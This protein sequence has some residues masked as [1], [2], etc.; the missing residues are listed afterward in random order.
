MALSVTQPFVIKGKPDEST[1]LNFIFNGLQIRKQKNKF[2]N[3]MF[4]TLSQSDKIAV[5]VL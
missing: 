3:C 2:N 1:V 4:I 5:F